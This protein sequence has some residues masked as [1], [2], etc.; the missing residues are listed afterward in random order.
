MGARQRL[1]EGTPAMQP[2]ARFVPRLFFDSIASFT[3]RQ[4]LRISSRPS[5]RPSTCLQCRIRF[6]ARHFADSPKPPPPS[7]QSSSSS[8]TPP[9]PSSE[10]SSIPPSAPKTAPPEDEPTDLP[11]A[12]EGR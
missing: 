10:T 9:A 7:S 4:S 1:E 3:P 2:L 8:S 6:Q 5:L 12:E 11:S